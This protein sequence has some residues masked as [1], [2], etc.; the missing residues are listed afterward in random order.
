[1]LCLDDRYLKESKT[2][3]FFRNRVEVKTSYK[4]DLILI[5]Q[6]SDSKIVKFLQGNRRPNVLKTDKN[7]HYTKKKTV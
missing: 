3:D 1:M 7:V 4:S 2:T 6:P 5:V